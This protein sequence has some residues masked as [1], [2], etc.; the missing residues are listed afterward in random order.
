M[1]KGRMQTFKFS[2]KC[3]LTSLPFDKICQVNNLKVKILNLFLQTI[4]L[5]KGNNF[6][7]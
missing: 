7:N 3:N 2:T 4:L 1:L 5:S 6:K